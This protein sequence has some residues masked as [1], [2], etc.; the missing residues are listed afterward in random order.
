MAWLSK[1]INCCFRRGP[2]GSDDKGK[3]EA[4]TER[5]GTDDL[6]GA[7]WQEPESGPD[8]ETDRTGA[9]APGSQGAKESL[10]QAYPMAL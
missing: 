4:S 9:K 8:P 10:I 3:N 1:A 6:L 5:T 2:N 7:Y